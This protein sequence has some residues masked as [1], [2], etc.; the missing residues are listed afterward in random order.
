M[1]FT[2]K[3]CPYCK[4]E[5]KE[6]DDIVVCSACEMP[7]H[8]ECWI[9]NKG[10]TTFGCTGTIKGIKN[11]NEVLGEELHCPRCGAVCTKEQ[12]FCSSCGTKLR[13]DTSFGNQ[14]NSGNYGQDPS[15]YDDYDIYKKAKDMETFI[16]PSSLEY[17]MKKFK[18]L[19][20]ENTKVSWNWGAF[21]FNL[22][23]SCYRKMYG[24]AALVIVANFLSG[25][26]WTCIVGTSATI[27]MVPLI[28]KILYAIFSNYIYMKRAEKYI[29]KARYMDEEAKNK[30]LM[31]KGGV[32][33]TALLI[34]IIFIVAIRVIEQNY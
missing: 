21:W 20:E 14:F 30:Y 34:I 33:G 2:G 17:Y 15:G 23:W 29:Q 19:N 31:K 25:F 5:F 24:M 18:K 8:K 6:G 7:H 13:S 26:V 3:I 9:E 16:G 28:I 22:Y 12:E 11:S 1:D 4:T 10:C 32:S 27:I